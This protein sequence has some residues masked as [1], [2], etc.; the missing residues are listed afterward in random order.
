MKSGDDCL[1]SDVPCV[2]LPE[3]FLQVLCDSLVSLMVCRTFVTYTDIYM[4]QL[5]MVH[6]QCSA[7]YRG[8]CLQGDGAPQPYCLNQECCTCT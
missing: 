1:A 6:Q 5:S 7:D 8:S 3:I 2:K 4:L